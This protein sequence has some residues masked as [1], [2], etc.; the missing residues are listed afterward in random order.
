MVDNSLS[1][2]ERSVLV[3]AERKKFL[4]QALKEAE[5]KNRIYLSQLKLANSAA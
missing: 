4:E 3:I 5:E 1:A 2:S